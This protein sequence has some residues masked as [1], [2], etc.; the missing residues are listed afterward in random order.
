MAPVIEEYLFRGVV[1]GWLER[2]CWFGG[3]P[4]SLFWGQPNLRLYLAEREARGPWQRVA[5]RA[6]AGRKSDRD[7]E[8]KSRRGVSTL[9]PLCGR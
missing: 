4:L 8:H 3:S 6:L 5:T 7:V 2:L 9:P 1:Q